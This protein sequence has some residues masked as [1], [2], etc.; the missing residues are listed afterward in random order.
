MHY[1]DQSRARLLKCIDL[2]TIEPEI[3]LASVVPTLNHS[4]PITEEH[5]EA[6]AHFVA[7]L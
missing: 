5:S 4:D 1:I 2:A 6:S 3:P 7:A